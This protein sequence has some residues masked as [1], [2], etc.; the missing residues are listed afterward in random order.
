MKI[1][2]VLFFTDSFTG[3]DWTGDTWDETWGCCSS[4]QPCGVSEGHCYNDDECLGHLLCGTDNCFPPFRWDADCCY[5]PFPGKQRFYS[6][7]PNS[8]YGFIIVHVSLLEFLEYL[9]RFCF[10]SFIKETSKSW[11]WENIVNEVDYW[12][13][14]TGIE[15]MH[16][17][18][19]KGQ[20]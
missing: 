4:S 13:N 12:H 8:I 1:I 11:N 20:K 3:C 14:M 7:C 16:Q 10:F 18:R 5:D 15:M 17:G 9:F 2:Y 19:K 6:N